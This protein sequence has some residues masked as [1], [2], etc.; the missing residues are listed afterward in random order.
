MT[1]ENR[2]VFDWMVFTII[3]L[4]LLGAI[5]VAGVYVY[6]WRL[7]LWVAASAAIAGFASL[8]LF[9]KEVPGETLMKCWL[10]L[11][12]ALNAAYII[13]NGAKNMGI[14][15][16][17]ATQVQRYERGMEAAGKATS[18]RIASTLALS[19][20]SASELE[21]TF[22]DG[23]ALIAAILAF[24][25]LA[26]ALVIFAIGSR[27]IAKPEPIAAEYPLPQYQ[28]IHQPRPPAYQDERSEFP[29]E[30]EAGK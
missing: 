13:H 8:Y 7:G 2:S 5:S 17:N 18:R 12:V 23:V 15:K 28:V 24:L 4:I 16:Y 29:R 10:G 11:C 1:S 22:G 20:K 6:G 27:R 21:K 3:H 25:E 9:A 14:E 30:I 26:S 19:A